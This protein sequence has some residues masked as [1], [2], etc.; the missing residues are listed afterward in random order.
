MKLNLDIESFF[1]VAC[2]TLIADCW[3]ILLLTEFHIFYNFLIHIIIASSLL[4]NLYI[5]IKSKIYKK[6]LLNKGFYLGLI[7][8][9]LI[10][11]F[12]VSMFYESF[13]GGRDQGIYFNSAVYLSSRH[14]LIMPGYLNNNAK[15]NESVSFPGY[16]PINGEYTQPQSHFGYIVWLAAHYSIAGI[17]GIKWSNFLPSVLGLISIFIIIKKFRNVKT[18]LVFIFL[19]SSSLP[20]LYFARQ[21]LTELFTLFLIFFGILGLIK[22]YESKNQKYLLT[23]LLVF[24]FGLHTRSEML[25]IF[26]IVIIFIIYTCLIKKIVPQNSIIVLLCAIILNFMVYSFVIQP[27]TLPFVGDVISKLQNQSGSISS[28][29]G[30]ETLPNDLKIADTIALNLQKYIFLIFYKY[31]LITYIFLG[32]LGVIRIIA[33]RTEK[34]Y[35]LI[36]L[37]IVFP[38]FYYLKNPQ[39]SFD[40]PWFFRR[41]FFAVLPCS[42]MYFSILISFIKSKVKYIIL[43]LLI[44]INITISSQ[45]IFYIENNNLFLVT[46]KISKLLGNNSITFYD[47]HTLNREMTILADPLYFVFDKRI[48]YVSSFMAWNGQLKDKWIN[49]DLSKYN[50]IYLIS[51]ASND[52]WFNSYISNYNIKEIAR[53][54]INLTGIKYKQINHL[55]NLIEATNMPGRVT[56][57]ESIVVYKM[58]RKN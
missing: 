46:E 19:F 16:V 24:G 44:L 9:V 18:G 25:F 20:F 32:I 52:G 33:N 2:T 12:N 43:L 53:Y 27:N 14:S 21:T 58:E 23:I 1:F 51:S 50:N 8:I 57:E 55:S 7:F 34:I 42:F 4:V 28:I 38:T 40:H 35:Y 31:G 22:F 45:Y 3:L 37:L 48:E 15:L 26:P 30:I 39:I 6:F 47:V 54:K 10:S 29:G 17:N 41:Y 13:F 49:S 56:G 36:P 11:L 5:F